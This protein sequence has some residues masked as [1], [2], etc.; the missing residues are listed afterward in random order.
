MRFIISFLSA[1]SFFYLG[2]E[3]LIRETG[4]IQLPKKEISTDD[5]NGEKTKSLD[6]I[7]GN[8]ILT[9]DN[10]SDNPPLEPVHIYTNSFGQDVQAPTFYAEAPE[11]ATAKCNDGSFS[12]SKNRRG[13]CSGHG[14]VAEWLK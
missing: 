12:F 10:D 2:S 3:V 13:T 14:G 8:K 6:F 4:Q 9:D 1:F 11:N 5:L 7:P